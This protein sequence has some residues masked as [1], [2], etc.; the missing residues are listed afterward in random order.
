MVDAGASSSSTLAETIELYRR[1]IALDYRTQQREIRH[2]TLDI[3]DA[4]DA[5]S[6]REYDQYYLAIQEMR[7][8]RLD[9]E[10]AIQAVTH[11]GT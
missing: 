9:D 5:L 7:A 3:T 11:G 6:D 4:L 1:L 2:L 10:R 8:A